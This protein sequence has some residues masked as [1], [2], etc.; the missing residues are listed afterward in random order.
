[1][2]ARSKATTDAAYIAAVKQG[3]VFKNTFPFL[4]H[5]LLQLKRML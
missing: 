5:R 1:M 2:L 3:S 4:V